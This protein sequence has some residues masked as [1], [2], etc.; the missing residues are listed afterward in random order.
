MLTGD[1][2]PMVSEE[3]AFDEAIA[4]LNR[5]N[6]GAVLITSAS[7]ELRGII[8]DGDL[9]RYLISS[10]LPGA[11]RKAGTDISGIM[12]KKPVSI[13]PDLMA[14]DALSLMQEKDITVLAVLNAQGKVLGIL[15]LHD[16][17]GKGEFRFLI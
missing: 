14:A 16:L 5:K 1:K 11:Q 17:L 15:H 2:V 7:G 6:L 13:G 3:A 12:T 8:T 10:L 4:E 9:R